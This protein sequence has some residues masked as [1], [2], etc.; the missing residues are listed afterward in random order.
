[1]GKGWLSDLLEETMYKHYCEEQPALVSGIKKL[2]IAGQ[3][4]RQIK[5]HVEKLIGKRMAS[6]CIGFMI[7]YA[8]KQVNS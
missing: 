3:T 7:D 5:K 6:N 4:P 2:L 8:N 1:M